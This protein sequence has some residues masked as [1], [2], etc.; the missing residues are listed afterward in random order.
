[1]RIV[2]VSYIGFWDGFDFE[3]YLINEILNK[4]YKVE[5]V[6]KNAEY[7]FCSLFNMDFLKEKGVRI[8]YSGENY[9]PDF[10]VVDYAIGFEKIEF[11]DRY[12]WA[13]NWIMNPKYRNEVQLAQNKHLS[14]CEKKEFCSFVYSNANAEKIREYFY[15]KL[16]NYKKVN[17]G[18]RFLN[19]IG[20]PEG[21][22]DKLEF[23]K[24]HKFAIA[25]EN[26]MHNGY[27]TEKIISCF[28]A[29]TVPIYWGDPLINEI[30]NRNSYIN[31]NEFENIEQAVSFIKRIDQD[32]NLYENIQ[33]QPAFKDSEY[34]R[35]KEKEIEEFL[36][37][38]INQPIEQAYRRNV[39]GW[40][41]R[42]NVMH[43]FE[44]QKDNKYANIKGIKKMH[45]FLRKVDC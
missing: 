20:I 6:N 8:F 33:R 31:L 4:Y 22:S 18:G 44:R 26:S 2:K 14:I 28:A 10:N 36:L 12:I 17:S 41:D 42:Q 9:C 25:F 39:G 5:V 21:V 19:N 38:I 45:K 13:P 24:K 32:K 40:I 11:G 23:Q 15:Y 27:L 43:G 16:S 37:K 35:K 7:V 29:G 34:V 3:K 30:I 1:M